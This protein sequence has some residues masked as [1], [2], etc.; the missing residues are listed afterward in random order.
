MQAVTRPVQP[1]PHFHHAMMADVWGHAFGAAGL[2][3]IAAHLR[4]HAK[5]ERLRALVPDLVRITHS[6]ESMATRVQAIWLF[7]LIARPVIS[8]VRPAYTE[9]EIYQHTRAAFGL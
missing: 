4:N 9:P 7:R 3:D 2:T 5:A 6:S 8:F 1:L